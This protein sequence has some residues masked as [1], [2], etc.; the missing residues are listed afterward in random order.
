V[1]AA[2][3]GVLFL[4]KDLSGLYQGGGGEAN[5][6]RKGGREEGREGGSAATWAVIVFFV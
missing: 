2:L 1:P 3:V 5:A 6:G 4:V